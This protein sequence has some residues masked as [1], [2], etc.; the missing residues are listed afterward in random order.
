MQ[1]S[2]T[3][4]WLAAVRAAWQPSQKPPTVRT[5]VDCENRDK[6]QGEGHSQ[7]HVL[8]PTAALRMDRTNTDTVGSVMKEFK[9]L[10]LAR[11]KNMQQGVGVHQGKKAAMRPMPPP[12]V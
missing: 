3:N 5:N 2:S 10:D 11:D 7:G 9:A 6:G 1:G 4:T 12:S 8:R